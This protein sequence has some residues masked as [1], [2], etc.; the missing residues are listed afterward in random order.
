[1]GS[2]SMRS[3]IDD[4]LVMESDSDEEAELSKVLQEEEVLEAADHKREEQIQRV[5]WG[6]YGPKRKLPLKVERA[7]VVMRPA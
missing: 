2:S 7:D 1:M 5:L 6:E 3:P 4:T